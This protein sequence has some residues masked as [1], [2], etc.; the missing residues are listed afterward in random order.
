LALLALSVGLQAPAVARAS[1]ASTAP[2]HVLTGELVVTDAAVNQFRLVRRSGS[3]KA[4]DGTK[5]AALGGK[6]VRVEFGSDGGVL[7]VSP[8]DIHI[9]PITHELNVLS[10]PVEVRDPAKSTFTI[11]GDDHT[12][13]APRGVDI[14]TYD[15]HVV[16]MRVDEKGRVIKIDHIVRSADAPAPTSPSKCFIGDASVTPGSSICRRGTTF[17][18]ADGEWAK[19]GTVCD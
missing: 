5:V 14:R 4:P 17:R 6:P 3:F 2:D 15:G 1:N 19:T 12:Y 7:R 16:E 9:E 8:M 10:G 13:V 11:P 18:C